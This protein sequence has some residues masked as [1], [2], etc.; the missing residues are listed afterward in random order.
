[1]IIDIHHAFCSKP[2]TLTFLLASQIDCAA[3][4][5]WSK[6]PL[7]PAGLESS[8]FDKTYFAAFRFNAETS[9][10][11]DAATMSSCIPAP[12]TEPFLPVIST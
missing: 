12:Q 1:M 10:F 9:A 6:I 4:N 8:T 7:P 2:E 11:N 3:F 5:D